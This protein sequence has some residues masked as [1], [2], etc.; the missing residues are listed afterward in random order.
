MEGFY[1]KTTKYLTDGSAV[2]DNMGGGN[3]AMEGTELTIP[4]P[5]LGS[6]LL[7]VCVDGVAAR[8]EKVAEAKK[9]IIV[10]FIMIVNIRPWQHYMREMN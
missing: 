2:A 3:G 4:L 9:G 5:A 6:I 7:A 1:A 8:G 10:R